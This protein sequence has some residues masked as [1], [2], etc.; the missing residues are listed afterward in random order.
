[1]KEAKELTRLAKVL[2]AGGATFYNFGRGTNAN[3]IF[4]EL[5]NSAKHEYGHGGYTGTIAEKDGFKVVASPMTMQQARQKADEMID[6]N[7]KWGPAFAIPVT[8]KTGEKEILFEEIAYAMTMQEAAEVVKKQLK[9]KYES[10]GFTFVMGNWEAKAEKTT[11]VSLKVRS[12][13]KP[14]IGYT[15]VSESDFSFHPTRDNRYPDVRAA[16]EGMKQEI[17][18]RRTEGKNLPKSVTIKAYVTNPATVVIDVVPRSQ[19]GNKYRVT[20]KIIISK[21]S[22]QVEGY[23]FFGWASD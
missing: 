14:T 17:E 11:S 21:S 6:Q 3:Q 4:S 18:L 20:G 2:V 7:E 1:M 13:Q 8:G 23:L 22:T 19:R 10:K 12:K 15:V 16:I 5:V 9:E